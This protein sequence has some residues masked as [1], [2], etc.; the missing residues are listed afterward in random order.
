MTTS[1]H[2]PRRAVLRGLLAGSAAMTL[3]LPRIAG[4]Q[5]PIEIVWAKRFEATLY[6]PATSIT[7]S[8]WELLHILYDGL[9]EMDENMQPMPGL[10]TA[11]ETPDPLTYLFTIREGVTFHNGRTMT[12]A[13][14]AG[15]LSRLID[16]ATGSFFAGQM[17]KITAV[18][19]EPDNRVKITLSEPWAPMLG[20]LSS[21]MASII[22]MEELAAGTFDPTTQFNGTGP[23]M[24]ESHA[25]GD[26]WVLTRNP[27]YWKA[28]QPVADRVVVR[29]IPTEQSLIAG[30]RD[31]TIHIA[32]FDASPDAS[33]LLKQV[34]NVEVV[35]N[36][37]TNVFWMFLNAVKEG[38]PF[39]DQKVRQAVVLALDRE[40]IA[41]VAMGGNAA[42]A[43]AMPP[44]FNA[45][46]TAKLPFYN[47]DVERSKALLAEA[48][49]SGLT[50][51]LLITAG[52]TLPAIGQ[53][54]RDS[55]AEAGITVNLAALDEGTVVTRMWVDNP[56]NFEGALS[57]YAGY[58]DPAMLPLWF[59]PEVAGFSAG[60]Q[61]SDGDLTA[62]INATRSLAAD[63]P[64]R[65][66][67]LQSLCESLDANANQ[68][69]LVTRVETMAY[70]T[71]LLNPVGLRNVD[72]YA[73]NVRGIEA[74][75]RT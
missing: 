24:V 48:G 27:N 74:W 3:G 13:D 39:K 53:V 19:V 71:D 56:G 54:I 67:A 10:A 16:P 62:V 8:S 37:Q 35:Q 66:A 20:A 12:P 4:A 23:Y 36:L 34:D 40:R 41:Q 72:G 51:E 22:P 61:A 69:P 46:D 7:A 44:A 75:V 58:S 65:P 2:L 5:T 73:N 11:W 64:A 28:G 50:F 32:Q 57:W 33:L 17:G 68:V 70:R 63:D 15:S 49:A 14:V 26:N 60:F 31:G 1:L 38:S 18:T 59:V 21:T 47:R 52:T 9:T 55:L 45:C 42:P 25:Q 30:L 43:S 29:I 6:D